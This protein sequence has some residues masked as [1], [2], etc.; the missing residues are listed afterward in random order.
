[1]GNKLLKRGDIQNCEVRKI[2]PNSPHPKARTHTYS[3]E[4]LGYEGDNDSPIMNLRKSTHY[5]DPNS[6][7]HISR[8][9]RQFVYIKSH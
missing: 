8:F 1:M 2:Y 6:S 7:S 4:D 5:F 9:N 3:G